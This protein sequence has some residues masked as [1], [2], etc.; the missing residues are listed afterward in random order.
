MR[1]KSLDHKGRGIGR[2]DGKITFVENALPGE[3]VVIKVVKEKKNYNE[4]IT[5]EIKVKC[6]DRVDSNCPYYFC[7]G[8]CHIMHMNYQKQLSFKHDK[9]SNIFARYLNKNIKVN[10]IIYDKSINYRNKLKL[11]AKD[12]VG[13]YQ[14]GTNDIVYID[15]CLI[16][17]KLI[18]D[19]IN[20]LNN[21]NLMKVNEITIKMANN[22]LLICIDG[23]KDLDVSFDNIVIKDDKYYIIK[24]NDYIIYDDGIKYRISVE[25]FFQVNY[26]MMNKLYSFI[27]NNLNVEDRVLDLYC[28]TGSISLFIS[29]KVKQVD[30]VEKNKQ[31]INDANKNKEFN[32]ISNVYF[33][34]FDTKDIIIDKKY[35]VIIVDPPRS[36]LNKS[37]MDEVIKSH[38][39][40]VIYV[41]CDPMTLVRDLKYLNNY[42]NIES[43]TPFDMFPNTYHIETICVLNRIR[44]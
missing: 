8:G 30:G 24:G 29:D 34:C 2:I 32:N 22:K 39:D 16:C 27:K 6:Q 25:S 18:S 15:S 17:D 28:G 36:G 12:K 7:C 31:A 33:T 42:Y 11:Q 4:A 20:T 5:K 13:L 19:R 3:E 35:D 14:K 26:A 43:I 1:I 9:I 38:T 44:I 21:L 41:S 37:I 40:K 23:S 10:D